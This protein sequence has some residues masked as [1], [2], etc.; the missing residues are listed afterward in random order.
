MRRSWTFVALPACAPALILVLSACGTDGP[1]IPVAIQADAAGPYVY[2]AGSPDGI[3]KFYMGREI[4]Q[5]MGHP[6]AE[7]LERDSRVA[8]ERTDL[9]VDNLPLQPDHVV[10]DLGAGTG[11]F[12]LLIAARVPQG[13]V[14]AVD[15][16]PEMLDIIARRVAAGGLKNVQTVLATE[17]DPRLAPGSV[18]MVLLVDAYH[19]FSHPRE[20]M[21]RV[22]ESLKPTGKV[23]LI[24]YR[25]EDPAV[26]IKELHKMTEAQVRR[27]LSAAGLSWTETRG[28]LPQQHFMVFS[29]ASAP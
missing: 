4:A 17:T 15:I 9:L 21:S 24:E 27:E 11:Y 6:G 22:A 25:G 8:E 7:W 5:V 10:V 19:E 29:R 26:P 2:K 1:R 12:T 23:V 3:G 28:F 14:L 16:Q 13:R 18:D 20:V